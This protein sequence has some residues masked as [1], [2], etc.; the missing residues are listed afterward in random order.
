MKIFAA[1]LATETNTFCPVF[2]TKKNF[3]E[4]YLTYHGEHENPPHAW[5]VP[6]VV[7][8]EKSKFRGWNYTEGFFAAAQPS[9]VIIKKDYE[10]LRD[11]LL[12]DL[13]K[14]M[15]VNAVILNLHGAMVADGYDDCEGDILKRIREIVGKE[16]LIAALLDPHANLSCQMVENAEILVCYKEYPH[17]DVKEAALH[18]FHLVE[19]TLDKNIIPKMS[20]YD[21]KIINAY[22]TTLEPMKSFLDKIKKLERQDNILSISIIHGFPWSDVSDVGSKILVITDNQEETGIKLAEILGRELFNLQGKTMSRFY[23]INEALNL[24]KGS[25]SH[26]IILADYADNTGGGAPGDST[27]ILQ[28][29]IDSGVKNVALGVM[30]DPIAVEIATAAGVGTRLSL[31]IGGKTGKQSGEPVDIRAEVLSINSNLTVSFGGGFAHYGNS[32]AVRANG[33]DI[34]LASLR[35][36]VYS[37]ECFLKMKVSLHDKFLIVVKSSEHFRASFS[38]ISNKIFSVATEGALCPDFSKIPYTKVPHLM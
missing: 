23:S 20:V 12:N 21:C 15:P 36:Q 2:T 11:I 8:S 22:P 28:K 29:L 14:A 13:K 35:L 3:Q 9:G 6:L 16:V 7:F 33:I 4:E 1:G 19:Q 25:D 30:W 32:V 38:T 37:I 18:L 26:P 10:E 17:T 34:V 24:A 27:F 5:A 31:R